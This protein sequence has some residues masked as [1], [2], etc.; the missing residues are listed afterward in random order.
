MPAL[1]R[2]LL[3]SSRFHGRN[4]DN[5]FSHRKSAGEGPG[6]ARQ[7]R[8]RIPASPHPRTTAPR[9]YPVAAAIT[10]P[11]CSTAASAQQP[12]GSWLRPRLWPISWA[13]VAAA[14]MENSEWSWEDVA[15]VTAGCEDHPPGTSP[16]ASVP[17]DAHGGHASRA[18]REAHALDGRQAHCGAAESLAPESGA[19]HDRAGRESAPPSRD[20]VGVGGTHVSS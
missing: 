10:Q 15:T 4:R 13:M 20:R 5:H 2:E 16:P 12:W 3:P 6:P 18:L 1:G 7:P 19:R 11:P 14:P 9:G 17:G 8:P